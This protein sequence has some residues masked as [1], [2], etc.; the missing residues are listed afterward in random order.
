MKRAFSLA[1]LCL[2]TLGCNAGGSTP[3]DIPV[4]RDEKDYRAA[5]TKA[6]DLSLGHLTDFARGANLD[7]AA[8]ADL[9]EAR[10]QFDALVAYVP[11]SFAPHVGTGKIS[12]VLGDYELA[13]EHLTQALT[14]FPREQSPEVNV[15]FAGVNDDLANIYFLEGD[16]ATARRYSDIALA[17]DSANPNYLYTRASILLNE[18]KKDEARKCVDEGLKVDKS[19][20]RL[21]RL[22][23]LIGP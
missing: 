21:Q 1:W 22:K 19:N 3:D 14:L 7:D 2:L 15:T 18:K 4:I 23:K 10:K 6:R 12:Y 5:L 9:A 20:L 13:K 8:K 11:T 17:I 16:M